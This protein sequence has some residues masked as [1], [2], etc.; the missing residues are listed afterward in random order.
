MVS[1]SRSMRIFLEVNNVVTVFV[2]HP[3]IHGGEVISSAHPMFYAEVSV[4]C[5]HMVVDSQV[6]P[7]R[8]IPCGATLRTLY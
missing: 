3:T 4:Q 1:W 7:R 2:K 6:S 8:E 5:W